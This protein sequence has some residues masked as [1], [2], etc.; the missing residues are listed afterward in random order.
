MIL[1]DT[2]ILT[3]VFQGNAEVQKRLRSTEE[4]VATTIITRIEILQGRFDAMFKAAD[5]KPASPCLPKTV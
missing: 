1:L 3:L 4:P 2:D 5:A